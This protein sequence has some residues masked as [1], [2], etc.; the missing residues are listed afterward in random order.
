MIYGITR[1]A[2]RNGEKNIFIIYLLT[3]WNG[4]SVSQ[5]VTS[6][7]DIKN[8]PTLLEVTSQSMSQNHLKGV[9][10]FKIAWKSVLQPS[11]RFSVISGKCF[12]F[13][14]SLHIFPLYL[15]VGIKVNCVLVIG[16]LFTYNDF[17]KAFVDLSLLRTCVR[18][19]VVLALEF[20]IIPCHFFL[21]V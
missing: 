12:L 4:S 13:P 17:L 1:V 20:E 15:I 8:K 14:F 16:I 9:V 2:I 21:I 18:H 6:G 5:T 11:V 10:V 3:R 19:F 7:T